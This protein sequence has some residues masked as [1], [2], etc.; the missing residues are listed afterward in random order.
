MSGTGLSRG[1]DEARAFWAEIDARLDAEPELAARV[2]PALRRLARGP[3]TPG[4]R[5]GPGLHAAFDPVEAYREDADGLRDRLLALD[6]EQLKDLV[7]VYAMDPRKLAL[8]WKNK[9]R[10]VEFIN[11]VVEQRVRRGRAF[12]G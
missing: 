10:L 2:A 5:R 12:R 3:A 7:T 11:G 9:E 1:A 8:K 4:R 6:I